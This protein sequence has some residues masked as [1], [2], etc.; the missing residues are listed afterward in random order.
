MLLVT[1]D[2]LING[3]KNKEYIDLVIEGFVLMESL[4]NYQIN[5]DDANIGL[6]HTK[7][8]FLYLEAINYEKKIPFLTQ[9]SALLNDDLLIPEKTSNNLNN[10]TTRL[11]RKNISDPHYIFSSYKISKIIDTITINLEQKNY[12]AVKLI[13]F[14]LISSLEIWKFKKGKSEFVEEEFKEKLINLCLLMRKEQ[15][16]IEFV[17]LILEFLIE[18]LKEK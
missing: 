13:G 2:N 10:G 11:Q 4:K 17:K 9:L 15:N 5:T 14:I 7:L 18:D 16:E 1:C 6:L 12:E 3:L 8:T